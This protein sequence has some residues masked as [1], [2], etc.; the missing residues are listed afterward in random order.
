MGPYDPE[1]RYQ[2]I[3]SPESRAQREFRE[4]VDLQRQ[5]E[6]REAAEEAERY[7]RS[8]FVPLPQEDDV[9]LGQLTVLI[10]D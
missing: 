7:Q 8:R 9:S 1:R 5:R 4:N 3:E 10:Q 6:G 2:A